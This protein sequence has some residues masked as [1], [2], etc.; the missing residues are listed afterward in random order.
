MSEVTA[1]LEAVGDS[2]TANSAS[3]KGPLF[4][5]RRDSDFLCKEGRCNSS[6]FAKCCDPAGRRGVSRAAGWH[7]SNL[8]L[9]A[10]H[11]VGDEYS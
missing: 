9:S 5:P 6:F 11:V 4:M 8:H 10:L 7:P 1:A 3:H 2:G